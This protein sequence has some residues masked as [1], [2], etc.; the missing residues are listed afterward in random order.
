MDLDQCHQLQI[1]TLPLRELKVSLVKL[2]ENRYYGQ[3]IS[4]YAGGFTKIADNKDAPSRAFKKFIEAQEVLGKKIDDPEVLVD[5]GAC[6]GGWSYVARMQNAS[7]IAIDRSEVREDLLKDP[8]V[9]FLQKE[10]S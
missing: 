10:A 4:P 6:P 2:E 9:K 1:M 7:V 3:V 5:L 8:K